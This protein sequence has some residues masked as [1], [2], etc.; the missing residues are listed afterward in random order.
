MSDDDHI[1]HIHGVPVVTPDADPPDPGGRP[2]WPRREPDPNPGPIIWECEQC[3]DGIGSDAPNQIHPRFCSAECWRESNN[4][5]RESWRELFDER[6]PAIPPAPREG[7]SD[8]PSPAEMQ[9]QI[10]RLREGYDE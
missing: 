7:E 2:D 6:P 9:R 8:G 5:F 3:G 10:D 4:E 1:T